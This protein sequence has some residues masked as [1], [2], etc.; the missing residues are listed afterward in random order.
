MSSHR[1]DFKSYNE[2]KRNYIAVFDI[3]EVDADCYIELYEYY[4]CNTDLELK[5][6]EGEV[7]RLLDCCNKR[8]AGRTRKEYR[9]D[10]KERLRA[11][12]N[13]YYVN[14]K[15]KIKE[16]NKKYRD[17]NKQKHNCECGGKYTHN[18]REAH[19]RTKKH[20]AFINQ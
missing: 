19:F 1:H 17:N 2:G 8:I 9:E 15:E 4:P 6:R 11:E 14:N 3:F 13:Q 10:N 7:I 5:R 20:Q 18:N 12:N 16:R